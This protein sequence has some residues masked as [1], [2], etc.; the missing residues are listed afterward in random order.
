MGMTQTKVTSHTKS[1][2]KDTNLTW[3]G[4]EYIRIFQLEK[5]DYC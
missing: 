2:L 4:T 1:T 5:R 3:E